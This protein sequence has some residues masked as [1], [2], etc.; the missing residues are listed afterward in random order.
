MPFFPG[1]EPIYI[2]LVPPTYEFDISLI[3][4]GFAEGA[5]ALILCNPS[6]PCGKV[7]RR[8]ELEA[9]AK[10]AIQYDAFVVTDEVYEHIIY[11]PAEHICMAS[12]PGMFEHTIT[13]NSLSKT[14]SITGWRLGYLIGPAEVIEGARKVHDFSLWVRLHPCRRP[15][16][17]VWNARQLLRRA[18]GP[19]HRKARS[20]SGRTGPCGPEAQCSAGHL[21][22][23]DRHFDFLALPQ[24]EGWTDLEFCEWM[25]REIGVAAVP[26]SSFFREP[27][28]HLIRM[29]FA[30]GTDV[31]DE[32]VRRLEKNCPSF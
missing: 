9:I 10:L 6:N 8:D 14:Y 18:A 20:F 32:A 30:R 5:K 3:E 11:A 29:H 13:C 17:P 28:N 7:F 31:L 23:D 26:G 27:V 1:A 21:F 24:F 19:L 15:L 4:K 16:W 22:C 25:I 2:P 12:L